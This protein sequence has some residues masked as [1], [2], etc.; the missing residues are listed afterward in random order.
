M[1]SIFPVFVSICSIQIQ[2]KVI[3]PSN[4]M[5]MLMVDARALYGSKVD[6]RHLK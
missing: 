4:Y 3:N 6:T 2:C 1:T 5:N